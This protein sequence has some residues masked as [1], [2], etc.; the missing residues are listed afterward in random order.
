MG[1]VGGLAA[2]VVPPVGSANWDLLEVAGK[3]SAGEPP[4][5]EVPWVGNVPLVRKDVAAIRRRLLEAVPLA[6]CRRYLSQTVD[7]AAA[8]CPV[9]DRT[10]SRNFSRVSC[11][12]MVLHRQDLEVDTPDVEEPSK[13]A[14]R[15]GTQ[16]VLAPRSGRIYDPGKGHDSTASGTSCEVP[17]SEHPLPEDLAA[18]IADTVGCSGSGSP[19]RSEDTVR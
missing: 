7:A 18:G 5:I 10:E 16:D 3:P 8:A 17:L 9:D 11:T 1:Q 2:R 15:A 14:G 19:G 12:G 4:G 6:R 13:N